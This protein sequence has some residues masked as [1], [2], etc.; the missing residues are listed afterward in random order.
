MPLTDSKPD[1]LAQIYATSLFEMAESSGGRDAV[2]QVSG[3]LEDVIELARSDA[4][5]SEFLSSRV[6]K[7]GDRARSLRAMLEGKV[8]D[9]TLKFLLVLNEKGRLGHLV[10]IVASL[11]ETVQREFGRV[12]VDVYTAEALD[13]GEV[14]R[15][16]AQLRESLGRE[17]VVH[18]Y[19]EPGMIGGV[20]MQIGDRLIDASVASRLR[21][22]R[23]RL[24]SEGSAALRATIDR[25]FDGEG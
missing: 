20:K 10:P 16:G 5:F 4:S 23:D 11:D 21:S 14:E 8:H 9:L 1:A 22:F 24:A 7:Q 13:A 17:A 6:L 25:A 3:E 15:I 19:T 2:E 18:A 12:E